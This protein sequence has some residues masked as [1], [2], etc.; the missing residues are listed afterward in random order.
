MMT[1]WNLIKNVVNID[2]KD[3]NIL[4]ESLDNKIRYK[5]DKVNNFPLINLLDL[6]KGIYKQKLKNDL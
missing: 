3:V 4:H 2:P 6:E 1:K 5:F